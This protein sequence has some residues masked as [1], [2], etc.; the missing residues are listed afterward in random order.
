MPT[1]SEL[2]IIAQ[3]QKEQPEVMDEVLGGEYY[4]SAYE[5]YCIIRV[6]EGNSWW[7]EYTDKWEPEP[8]NEQSACFI[9][10][11][12]DVTPEDL[13]EFRAHGIQ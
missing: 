2:Q 13:E 4:W 12:R 1:F 11:I 6:Y 5:N 8:S 3:Y 10:C 7:G 9:R